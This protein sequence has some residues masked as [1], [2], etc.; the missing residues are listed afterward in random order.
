MRRRAKIY[1]HCENRKYDASGG[2]SAGKLANYLLRG[3]ENMK[4]GSIRRDSFWMSQGLRRGYMTSRGNLIKGWAYLEENWLKSKN[5]SGN[6][7]KKT[8]KYG[9]VDRQAQVVFQTGLITLP[10]DLEVWEAKVLVRRIFKEFPKDCPIMATLHFGKR[11]DEREEDNMHL[12]LMMSDRHDFGI[13]KKAEELIWTAYDKKQTP[14]IQ[15]I[16]EEVVRQFYI[17]FG[18]EIDE[19]GTKES[20]ERAIERYEEKLKELENDSS[21]NKPFSKNYYRDK[22]E[23]YEDKYVQKKV[24]EFDREI[25]EYDVNKELETY[26]LFDYYNNKNTKQ[27]EDSIDK[28]ESVYYQIDDNR[29]MLLKKKEVLED[30]NQKLREDEEDKREYFENERLAS[31]GSD[32]L[33]QRVSPRSGFKK[34][35]IVSTLAAEQARVKRQHELERQQKRVVEQEKIKAQCE[36]IQ[37]QRESSVLPSNIDEYIKNNQSPFKNPRIKR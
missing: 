5:S 16:I 4:K 3:E 34:P 35:K 19:P 25:F 10:N 32:V 24:E 12:H 6:K 29:D 1:V 27:V 17:D 22:I 15:E 9:A 36:K 18:Y 30:R 14:R 31:L 33:S 26:R 23:E 20:I 21:R 11:Y 8:V 7:R 2:K 13:G 28:E 37:A